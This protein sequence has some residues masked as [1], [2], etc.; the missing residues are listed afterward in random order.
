VAAFSQDELGCI[1]LHAPSGPAVEPRSDQHRTYTDRS[2]PGPGPLH[3]LAASLP[4]LFH[5]ASRR[6]L[7]VLAAVR[8]PYYGSIQPRPRPSPGPSLSRPDPR[9]P[10]TQ[11]YHECEQPPP[12]P[13]SSPSLSPILPHTRR[14]SIACPCDRLAAACTPPVLAFI[15]RHRTPRSPRPTAYRG[16]LRANRLLR[17]TPQNP[18]S[19]TWAGPRARGGHNL[20]HAALSAV[21]GQRRPPRYCTSSW[22]PLCGSQDP[23]TVTFWWDIQAYRRHWYDSDVLSEVR[24]C[25]LFS[26]QG[27]DMR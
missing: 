6:V 12:R 22:R 20:A 17:A 25:A 11:P 5:V 7:H 24:C 8:S 21:P 2:D 18:R 3:C 27:G 1:Q 4:S 13:A 16:P 19:A 10:A 15:R 14:A 23:R 26:C 9:P